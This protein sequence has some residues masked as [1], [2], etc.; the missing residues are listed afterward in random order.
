VGEPGTDAYVPATP[1]VRWLGEHGGETL[2]VKGRLT[3]TGGPVP[4]AD[5][6][7]GRRGDRWLR[8]TF[9]AGDGVH[10]LQRA[11]SGGEPGPW[12]R[13]AVHRTGE[14][15]PLGE[16]MAVLLKVTRSRLQVRL[17]GAMVINEP[18]PEGLGPEGRWG[19]GGPAQSRAR[20]ERLSVR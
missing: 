13:L 20:W 14:D 4:Q 12:E 2:T 11:E 7:F 3:L 10:L 17:G 5:L 16:E 8:L 18:R 15:V 6:V 9:V 1:A 19:V